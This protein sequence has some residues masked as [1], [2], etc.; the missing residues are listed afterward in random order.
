MSENFNIFSDEEIFKFYQSISQKVRIFREERNISQLEMAL[1]IDI[2]SV[3]FYSNCENNKY[4]KH[5]NLE[6]L[7]KICKVL[8][9]NIKDFFE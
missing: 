7:Y 9:L 3:A 6:H 1:S 5:F 2:K 8:N 4:N